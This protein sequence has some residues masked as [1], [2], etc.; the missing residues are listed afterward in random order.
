[1]CIS[2]RRSINTYTKTGIS[3]NIGI[4][5]KINT[6]SNINVNILI[7]ARKNISIVVCYS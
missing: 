3:I 4:R 1:M 5:K 2:V 7:R 6:S